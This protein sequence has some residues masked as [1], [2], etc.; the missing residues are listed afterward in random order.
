MCAVDNLEAI[1]TEELTKSVLQS[2]A[3]VL[4]LDDETHQSKWVLH[5]LKTAK[6]HS[7]PIIAV[8]DQVGSLQVVAEYMTG[9]ECI[10]S[11]CREEFD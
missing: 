9:L 5:E 11:L 6:D 2:C 10:G 3:I 1:D 4:F 8:V 7:I